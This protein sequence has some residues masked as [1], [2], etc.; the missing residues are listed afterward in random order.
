MVKRQ[1]EKQYLS[2]REQKAQGRARSNAS[3]ADRG[4]VQKSL[5]FKCCALTLVPFES[6]VCTVYESKGDIKTQKYGIVFDNAALTEFVWKHKKDPVTGNPLVSSKIIKLNMDQDSETGQWQCPVLTKAF[7]DHNTKIVAVISPSGGNEANVYSYEAYQELNV[8]PKSYVDLTTGLKFHP[9]KDVL[10]LNDPANEDFQKRVR[11]S[12]NF[13]HIRNARGKVGSSNSNSSSNKNNI[14]K[15]VTATRVMEE[16]KKKKAKEEEERAKKAKAAAA[17]AASKTDDGEP[18]FEVPGSNLPF[19]VP[20]EDVTGVKYTSGSAALGL[21]STSSG[22]TSSND[23]RGATPEEILESRFKLMKTWKGKKGYV[24][25][26]VQ[27]QRGKRRPPLTLPLLLELHCD[28]V[29]R[30]C[31]NFLGL[32]VQ[33]KYD[34]TI[35]HRL[36][37]DFMIQG[38]G[39]KLKQSNTTK[40]EKPKDACLWGPDGFVD[41]FENRLKHTEGDGILAMANAG[42]NTNKQQFYITLGRACPHLDRKHSV[43]GVVAKGMESFRKALQEEVTTDSKDRPVLEELDTT[44]GETNVTNAVVVIVAAEVLEDPYREA[45]EIEDKRLTELHRHREAK[46]LKRKRLADGGKKTNETSN[47]ATEKKQS[48]TLGVGKYLA[49]S[50]TVPAK[51]G[52]EPTAVDTS[53]PDVG[54]PSSNNFGLP[55]IAPVKQK[56]KKKKTKFGDFSSW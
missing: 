44:N 16:I 54:I 26:V 2:S 37:N 27:V 41:E 18:S 28:M 3:S 38:G 35:F 17:A 20:T 30:T 21:T 7:S 45:K 46:S 40:T 6:P 15:S 14:R 42:P 22:T 25:L 55:E 53:A 47:N 39:E 5:P 9:K 51:V 11:D 12:T 50:T 52:D 13:W 33:K 49:K 56:K 48:I 8:K 19:V 43:F 36:I 34:G 23:S 10:I 4:V 29:P 31:S 32:C 24:N 1:K